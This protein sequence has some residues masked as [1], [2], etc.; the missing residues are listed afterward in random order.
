GGALH[1]VRETQKDQAG[2][3]T[4]I[5]FFEPGDYLLLDAPTIRNLELIEALDG[6]RARTLVGVLDET[7]TGM[8]ARLLKQWIMRPSMRVGELNS[9]LDSIEEMKTAL[10]LRDR[11][12][13]ELK[14]VAD[15]ERLIGRINL[16]R[17]T[18]R[19]LLALKTSADAIPHVKE[20]LADATSSLMEVLAESLD[21]LEDVRDLI[22][23][24]I[25]D[26]PPATTADGGYL[27]T[28]YNPQLDEIREIATSGKSVIARIE[29]RERELTGVSSL[30]VKFNNVFG[31]F[32]EIS[33]AN[34][35]NVPDHYERRR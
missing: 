16:G 12:R 5:S 13:T 33:K 6:S 23:K 32:I 27:R 4:G 2:H 18:P 8:G 9:R 19:D 10:I 28:G 7:V 31:Y 14:K 30:K 25:A 21:E 20:L 11:L 22:G 34:L 29:S 3:I 15:L 1:Y 24:S 17:A 26:D 35:K